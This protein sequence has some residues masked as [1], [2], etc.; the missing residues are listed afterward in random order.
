IG[1]DTQALSAVYGVGLV[2]VARLTLA[3]PAAFRAFVA[4]LEQRSGETLPT[5]RVDDVDYWQLTSA[6]APLRG[7]FALHGNHLVATI[8][9]VGDDAALRSLL[10]IERPANAL[11][12][13]GE[14][15]ALNARYGFSPYASGYVD[16]A[17]IVALLTSPA[18]PLEN[19]FLQ[20]M[21]I[22]K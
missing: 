22:E 17:R 5:G 9:P 19:A 2:P 11:R 7:V 16:S 18:T 15:A 10:G 21:K 8:A 20:A 3:D 13:G 14:L 12:D 4:R 1:L 6:E